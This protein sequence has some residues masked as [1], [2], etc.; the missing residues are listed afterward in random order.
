MHTTAPDL[1]VALAYAVAIL[2]RVPCTRALGSTEVADY[3]YLGS[4]FYPE[5]TNPGYQSNADGKHESR[6]EDCKEIPDTRSGFVETGRCTDDTAVEMTV[7]KCECMV[8]QKPY[9]RRQRP[10]RQDITKRRDHR[11]RMLHP[12]HVIL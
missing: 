6:C 4:P 1:L 8:G 5:L 10:P 7:K 12:P 9:R 11:R 2:R 3:D